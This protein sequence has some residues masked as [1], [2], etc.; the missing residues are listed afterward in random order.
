MGGKIQNFFFPIKQILNAVAVMDVPINNQNPLE[1]K[2]FDRIACGDAQVVKNAK[3]AR[4][5]YQGMMARV[6][7]HGKADIALFG[8][9]DFQSFEAP[10]D[11]QPGGQICF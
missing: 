2:L 6:S 9:Q 8:N 3:T 11:S 5:I 7:D 4:A 10:S 1:T